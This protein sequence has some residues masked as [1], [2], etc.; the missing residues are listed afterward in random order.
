MLLNPEFHL[1][2]SLYHAV[3]HEHEDALLVTA[4]DR[5]VGEPRATGRNASLREW[6]GV[7]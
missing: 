2:D 3:A 5:Y 1:F 6:D 7:S 4:D